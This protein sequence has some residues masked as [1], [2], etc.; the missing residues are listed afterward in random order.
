M[1]SPIGERAIADALRIGKA[2][3]KFISPNDAGLTRSH[4][5]GFF[6]PVP[7]WQLVTPQSPKRGTNHD[8]PVKVTWQDGRVTKSTVKWYG[9]AKSEYRFTGFGRDFP[10]RTAD[11]VGDLL[12]IVPESHQH[13]FA[14]VLDHDDDIIEIQAAL[15]VEIQDVSAVYDKDAA[16]FEETEDDCIDRRLRAFVDS[17]ESFPTTAVFSDASREAVNLCIRAL[18]TMTADER[19]MLWHDT[20][21][22]LFKMAERKLCASQIAGRVFRSVDEFLET[23]QTI[24]QRRKSR[25]GWSLENHIDRLLTEANIPHAMRPIDIEGRPDIVIPGVHE[26]RDAGFPTDKL[27]VIGVKSTCKDRWRQVLREAPR[28]EHRTIITLQRG[29]SPAQLL[30]M[31]ASNVRLVVPARFHSEYP[32]NVNV[33]ILKLDDFISSVRQT[34][35]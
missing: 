21:F 11:N 28:V 20:E 25:A 33:P 24:L 6:L 9:K 35:G 27:I 23:A 34:L 16:A 31:Q 2:V 30:E 22:A 17:L 3:L 13:F 29:I 15:G 32:P 19:F 14:Y 8:S 12:V 10:F 4:Q 18:D 7:S 1:A 26:Y 5:F